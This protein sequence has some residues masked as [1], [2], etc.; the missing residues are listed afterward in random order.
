MEDVTLRLEPSIAI[1]GTAIAENAAADAVKNMRVILEPS[2]G[3]S[4]TESGRVQYDGNFA[5]A[6]L[7][8]GRYRVEVENRPQS[9]YLKSLRCGVQDATGD[10]VVDIAPDARLALLF[11]TDGG[12]V[13]GSFQPVSKDATVLATLAPTGPS[14]GRMDLVKTVEAESRKFVFEGVAPGEYKLFLWELEDVAITGY[15]DFRRLLENQA[16]PLE[17]HARETVT[18]TPKVIPAAQVLEARR[19]LR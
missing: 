18:L 4:G 1:T 3:V 12:R 9:L 13:E 2:D 8:A 7:V 16:T 10:A 14:Q 17:V 19:K 5:V 6:N 15:P 11:G